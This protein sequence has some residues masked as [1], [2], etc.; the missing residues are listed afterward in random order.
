MQ[1]PADSGFEADVP[2]TIPIIVRPAAEADHP[3]IARIQQNSPEAA[4]WPL[5]D[6]SGF[7]VLVAFIDERPVGFCCWRQTAPDETELLN[8]AVDPWFRRRGV[9]SKL[10]RTLADLGR[11]AIFLEVAETNQSA[12][13]LYRAQGWE[14][15]GLRPGYYH[16]GTVNAVV[17]KK[18]TC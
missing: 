14:Q 8:L 12:I 6:Y 1:V 10:L 2:L 7:E 15:I 13:A 17:M 11:G 4:Q 3:A 18:S 9:A 16:H 5:G